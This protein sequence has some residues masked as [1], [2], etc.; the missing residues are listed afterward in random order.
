[1]AFASAFLSSVRRGERLRSR[2]MPTPSLLE[3]GF[4]SAQRGLAK[5]WKVRVSLHIVVALDLARV[6]ARSPQTGGHHGRQRMA[7]R[8]MRGHLVERGR[9][10][11]ATSAGVCDAGRS[12]LSGAFA[13]QICQSYEGWPMPLPEFWMTGVDYVGARKFSELPRATPCFERHA[14]SC[15]RMA[16]H[17]SAMRSRSRRHTEISSA[18][19]KRCASHDRVC[20]NGRTRARTTYRRPDTCAQVLLCRNC[21]VIA[22]LCMAAIHQEPRDV[23][24][25]PIRAC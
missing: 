13:P 9:G 4:A 10:R 19:I 14:T 3:V 6:I 22:C 21:V 16:R 2:L 25:A 15:L 1:M 8:G 17:C 24:P 23:L 7:A 11:I 12:A 20:P 18:G 5:R